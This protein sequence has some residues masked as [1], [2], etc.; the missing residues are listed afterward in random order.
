MRIELNDVAKGGALPPVSLSFS[1]GSATLA[2]TETEQRPTVLGLL[3]SGRMRPGTG[4]ITVDGAEDPKRMRAAVAL[5]DAPAVSE[6]APDVT[7]GGVTAEELVFAGRPSHPRAVAR[8]LEG[9]GVAALA[10]R[11]MSEIPA[12]ERVRVL[13][14]LALLRSGVQALVIVSPDRH[15]GDPAGW[16]ALAKELAARGVA[17]LVIAGTASASAI[18]AT[19]LLRTQFDPVQTAPVALRTLEDGFEE[20]TVGALAAALPRASQDAPPLPTPPIDPT[21]ADPEPLDGTRS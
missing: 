21:A 19:D 5:V 20:E 13:A 12:L 14:E 17:V 7:L 6:P 18:A 1:T 4:R 10:R 11:P 15:G 9:L 8:A 2:L 16:W 3:A